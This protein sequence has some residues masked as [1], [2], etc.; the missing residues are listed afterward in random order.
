MKIL[1]YIDKWLLLVSTVLFVIGLVMVFSS[2]NVAAF[3]RYSASPYRFVVKQ[4]IILGVG[5]IGSLFVIRISTKFYGVVSWPGLLIITGILA[6][7][8]VY[9]KIAGGAAS[10]IDIG[11]FA[12][13]PSEF[14]KV[15]MIVWMASFYHVNKNRL[16][17]YTVSL[18]PLLICAIIVGLLMAQP[19]LGTG[20]IFAGIVGF[21]FMIVPID[22]KI[23]VRTVAIVLVL[24]IIAIIFIV[25]KGGNLFFQHQVERFDFTNPCSEEKFYDDGNQVCNGYIAFNNGGLLG[26]GLGNSTQKYL[27]LPD[28]HTDFIFPIVIEEMGLLFGILI[29]LLYIFL[30]SRIIIIAHNS[31]NNRNAIMCYGI[32]FYIFFH[33]VVNL[34]GVTGLMPMTGIPLPFLSYGGSFTICLVVALAIVQRVAIENNTKNLSQNKGK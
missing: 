25:S 16:N 2:S 4:A 7:V 20:I 5:I 17:K 19:D 8:L 1:K 28:S 18:L 10:W 22:L 26:K 21:I 32:A 27:Y 33:I 24:A 34:M 11:P 6:L 31:T 3:M 23:K 29:I 15:I 13:Q 12:F 30:L 14:A 9:G